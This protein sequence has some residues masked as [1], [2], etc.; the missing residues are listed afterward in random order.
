MAEAK[1][2]SKVVMCHA[3]SGQYLADV[4]R[5]SVVFHDTY[6]SAG[7]NIN[8]SWHRWLNDRLQGLSGTCDMNRLTMWLQ[9]HVSEWNRREQG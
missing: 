7:T 6:R 3:I 1:Q 5:M 8:E 4:W 2:P 9:I